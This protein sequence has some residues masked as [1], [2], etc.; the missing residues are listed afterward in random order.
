MD[1]SWL[2]LRDLEYVLAL[3][4][5]KHFGRAAKKCKVSQPSLSNQIKKIEGYLGIELFERNNRRF[6]VT[7]AG[8]KLASQ[9]QV[10]LDEARKIPSLFMQESKSSTRKIKLGVISTLIPLVGY[11]LPQLKKDFPKSN[12]LLREGL[13]ENLIEELRSGAIDV[14]LSARTFKEQGLRVIPLFFEPFVLAAPKN[15][16]ILNKKNIKS[17]DL[18]A[19]EMVLLEDGHCLRNQALELCPANRRGN[20]QQYHVASIETL[21]YLVA[22]GLGYSLLPK[23]AARNQPMK[24]LIVYRE[25]AQADIGRELVLVCRERYAS[26][27]IA[28][29]T[30]SILKSRPKETLL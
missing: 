28:R 8:L 22:S 18:S 4:E 14:V 27:D 23:M 26:E 30:Q 17:S 12:L 29:L 21:R 11:F 25:F 24:E 16:S 15:H 19:S 13:T 5:Q 10:I 9:A 1:V 2:T 7:E 20:I 6:L 3:S